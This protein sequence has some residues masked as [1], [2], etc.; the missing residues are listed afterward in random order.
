MVTFQQI[1]WAFAI[2][3]AAAAIY[4][5]YINRILG[6]FVKYLLKAD[7]FDAESGVSLDEL[8]IKGMSFI[9]YSLREGSALSETVKCENGK[10]YIPEENFD[11]AE[12]KY[13]G[14]HLSLLVVFLLLIL[15]FITV[16]VCSYI[17]P[18]LFEMLG[19]YA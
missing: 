16:L 12:H 3:I 11:K 19:I 14:E 4:S 15:L 9:K 17:F 1:L 8:N 10:Y 2:G 6:N 7:A 18:E 13:C 5:F